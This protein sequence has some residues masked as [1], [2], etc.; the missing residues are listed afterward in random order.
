ML[1]R[2]ARKGP[3]VPWT[4]CHLQRQTPCRLYSPWMDVPSSSCPSGSHLISKPSSD[5]LPGRPTTRLFG[6]CLFFLTRFIFFL[7]QAIGTA[8]GR[9]LASSCCLRCLSATSPAHPDNWQSICFQS[10]WNGSDLLFRS[11][12]LPCQQPWSSLAK[13]KRG[14]GL[15]ST[16]RDATGTGVRR[17]AGSDLATWPRWFCFD[18]FICLLLFLMPAASLW[19]ISAFVINKSK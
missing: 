7:L 12:I 1:P 3:L 6:F 17:E 13:A 4:S 2:P 14:E 16:R 19:R 18:F 8:Y 5:A 11:F 10:P 15:S 9:A